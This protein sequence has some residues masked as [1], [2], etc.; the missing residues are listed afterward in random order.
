MINNIPEIALTEGTQK[1]DFVYIDDVVNAYEVIIN[2]LSD[3]SKFS[4]FDIASGQQ[5]EMRKIIQKIFSIVSEFVPVT[6]KLNFGAIAYRVGEAMTVDENIQP[7]LNLGW[8]PQVD[9]DKGLN[10]TIKDI[11]NG[12]IRKTEIRNS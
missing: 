5:I 9:I 11:F 2:R 10:N 4:E 1:R 8:K 7:I 6:S 12:S 3:L